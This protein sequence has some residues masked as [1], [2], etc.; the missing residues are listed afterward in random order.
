MRRIS[1]FVIAGLVVIIPVLSG[2]ARR[3]APHEQNKRQFQ[4]RFV[5]LASPGRVEGQG[6][7]ISLGAGRGRHRQ[8]RA[9]D[10]WAEGDRGNYPRSAKL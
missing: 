3:Q 10:G 8:S 7:T 1:R 2:S 5:L 9:C 4:D 6:E